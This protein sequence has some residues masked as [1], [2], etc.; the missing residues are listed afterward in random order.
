MAVYMEGGKVGFFSGDIRKI[1]E[2]M[3]A[4]KPTGLV[5]VPRLLNRIFSAVTGKA[6]GSWIKTTMLN[7]GVWFKERDLQRYM[8]CVK[9]TE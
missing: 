5:V 8:A 6:K 4:L 9:I 2:D 7:L 1:N 3:Q